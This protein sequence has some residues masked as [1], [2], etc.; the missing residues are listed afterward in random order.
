MVMSGCGRRRSSSGRRLLST[1]RAAVRADRPLDAACATAVVAERRGENNRPL[2][3]STPRRVQAASPPLRSRLRRYTCRG[4][5]AVA[6]ER[7]PR[8]GVVP[9]DAQLQPRL[10]ERPPT[11]AA[12]GSGPTPRVRPKG[13]RNGEDWEEEEGRTIG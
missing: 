9:A 6:A 11:A 2:S 3:L 7:A 1:A 10:G 13:K 4:H 5:P 8:A 12:G